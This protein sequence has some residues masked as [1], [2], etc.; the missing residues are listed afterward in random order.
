MKLNYN[1]LFIFYSLLFAVIV[2]SCTP[3]KD[4]YSFSQLEISEILATNDDS[5]GKRPFKKIVNQ[6]AFHPTV[7]GGAVG[8]A[9]TQSEQ[10]RR[11]LWLKQFA[12]DEELIQL[13]KNP[14]GNVKAY[15]FMALCDRNSNF[16]KQV[17]EQRLADKTQFHHLS[18]CI[19][20]PEY[21]NVFYLNYI[22]GKLSSKEIDIYKKEIS[23]HFTAEI[24]N[25]Y[26]E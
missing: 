8:I 10:Y 6:I 4:K 12:T 17:L 21:V 11:F 13:T 20:M 25:L 5:A 16:C 22:S 2:T 26:N 1:I 14:N 7:D 19:Q 23:K 24:G 15:S 18:G 9:G 3:K